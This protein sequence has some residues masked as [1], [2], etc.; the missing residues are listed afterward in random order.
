MKTRNGHL[1]RLFRR[2]NFDPVEELVRLLRGENMTDTERASI[3]LRLLPYHIPT[4]K[5][6]RSQEIDHIA[7]KE[8]QMELFHK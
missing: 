7:H 1:Q 6:V 5:A 2:H 4:L 8:Q 3:L